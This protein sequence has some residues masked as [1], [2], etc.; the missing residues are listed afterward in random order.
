VF[1]SG[2]VVDNVGSTEL[3]E[4]NIVLSEVEVVNSADGTL[5]LSVVLVDVA[6]SVELAL[7]V[8]SG[9][10]TG[11]YNIFTIL[12]TSSLATPAPNPG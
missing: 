12:T 9:T 4:L 2:T 5:L 7:L 10:T 8:G 6:T 11:P 3:V 1:V